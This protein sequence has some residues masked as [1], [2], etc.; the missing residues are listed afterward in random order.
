M[1]LADQ[2]TSNPALRAPDNY[3]I[4]QG[5]PSFDAFGTALNIG[6]QVVGAKAGGD[7]QTAIS[8]FTPTGE[9]ISTAILSVGRF[10]LAKNQQ[11]QQAKNARL[12]ASTARDSS[13]TEFVGQFIAQNFDGSDPRTIGLLQKAEAD[14]QITDLKDTERGDRQTAIVREAS[15]VYADQLKNGRAYYPQ[16]SAYLS[17]PRGGQTVA[18]IGGSLTSRITLDALNTIALEKT[19]KD[20]NN[21]IKDE[22]GRPEFDISNSV[23]DLEFVR[24]FLGITGARYQATTNYT[25]SPAQVYREQSFGQPIYYTNPPIISGDTITRTQPRGITMDWK[26]ILIIGGIAVVAILVFKKVVKK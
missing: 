7:V 1:G 5:A 22:T 21:I 14:L 15:V 17:Y 26:K 10:F 8:S 9:P 6:G 23:R 19:G 25:E 11:G 3:Y 4:N 12:V 16:D 24:G 13:V 20:V 2:A 18:N